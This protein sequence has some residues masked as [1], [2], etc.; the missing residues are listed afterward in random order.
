MAKII[1]FERKDSQRTLPLS[2]WFFRRNGLARKTLKV[3]KVSQDCALYKSA[4]EKQKRDRESRLDNLT[5]LDEVKLEEF[6]GPKKSLV[7]GFEE[8]RGYFPVGNNSYQNSSPEIFYS[9][10]EEAVKVFDQAVSSH[11]RRE[12]IQILFGYLTKGMGFKT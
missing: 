2:S 10:P 6:Y 12:K 7:I 5:R 11:K 4:L 3:S 8:G 1:K 9:S